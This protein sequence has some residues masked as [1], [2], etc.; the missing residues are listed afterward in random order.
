MTRKPETIAFWI[1][2]LPHWEVVDG[3]YFVTIHLSGAIPAQ[4]KRRILAAMAELRTAENDLAGQRLRIQRHIFQEMEVWLD[5][6]T[7]STELAI[8]SIANMV[9]EAIDHRSRQGDWNV[10]EYVIMPTHVHLFF[11]LHGGRL[12][13]ALEGFKDWTGH[14]ASKLIEFGRERFWQR[15]WFDHWS[16]S[17]EEDERISAYIR[18][19]P[20]KARLVADYSHWPYGSWGAVQRQPT[21]E[22]QALREVPPGGRDLPEERR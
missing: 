15:E 1:G 8:P 7:R 6:A 2:R 12:K 19:N 16:R 21:I 10:F 9:I 4:G 18:R 3:R 11:E 22:A 14:R 13:P 17:D 20:V 5:G